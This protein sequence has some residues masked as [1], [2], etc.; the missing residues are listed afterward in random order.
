MPVS[1]ERYC[2]RPGRKYYSYLCFYTQVMQ[3]QHKYLLHLQGNI[4]V[5]LVEAV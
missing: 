3:M 5:K 2:V 1:S 4:V